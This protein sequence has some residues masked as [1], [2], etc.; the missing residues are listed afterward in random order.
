MSQKQP[1]HVNKALIP[2]KAAALIHYRAPLL[3]EIVPGL[4]EFLRSRQLFKVMLIA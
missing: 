4:Q 2:R 1:P 3:I